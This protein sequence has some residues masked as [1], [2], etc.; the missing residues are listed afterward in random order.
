MAPCE[1]EKTFSGVVKGGSGLVLRPHRP[2]DI[3][4]VIRR[5][6]VLYA[7]EY[8]WD[9]TFEALV[10][11]VAAQFVKNFDAKRERCWIAERNSEPVG[12]VFLVKYTDQVAKLRLL[13]VEPEARGHGIGARLVAECVQFAR[14][15]G[16]LKITL[17]TQSILTDARK[18][19]QNAGFRLV[20]HEP[21]HAFGADLISETWEL[22]L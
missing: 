16:Y 18:L 17:W 2:G 4:W 14:L 12:S 22:E 19:Y 3:D 8:G 7:Q 6:G 9:A 10:A 20:K 11:E 21:Q 1:A 15:C 13:L 5:H